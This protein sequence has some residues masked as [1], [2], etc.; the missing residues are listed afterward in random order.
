MEKQALIDRLK[1]NKSKCK[2]FNFFG[3]DC[4]QVLDEMI[5]ILEK[6]LSPSQ[7]EDL[8]DYDRQEVFDVLHGDMDIEDIL[9]PE[10]L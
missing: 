5:E 10:V 3:E 7:S 2:Q 4:H 9:Y 1:E 8:Y 6:D